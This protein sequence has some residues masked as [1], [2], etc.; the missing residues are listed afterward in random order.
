MG[1]LVTKDPGG[2]G[3]FTVLT[4]GSPEYL[5]YHDK[6]IVLDD[7]TPETRGGQKLQQDE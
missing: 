5:I 6:G 7:G 2:V 4:A 1:L 3:W